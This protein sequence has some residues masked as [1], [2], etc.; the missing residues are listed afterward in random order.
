MSLNYQ[1]YEDPRKIKL[2]LNVQQYNDI[3]FKPK[4]N[5]KFKENNLHCFAKNTNYQRNNIKNTQINKLII[6]TIEPKKDKKGN[7]INEITKTKKITLHF[8]KKQRRIMKIWLTVIM[9]TYNV[10][11]DYLKEQFK[12][13]YELVIK[14]IQISKEIKYKNYILNI[15][16]KDAVENPDQYIRDHYLIDNLENHIKN[17]KTELNRL[18]KI[19]KSKQ[20]INML[21]SLKYED[22]RTELRFIKWILQADSI[23]YFNSKN[24]FKKCQPHINAMDYA[25][26]E[27]VTNYKTNIQKLM[28]GTITSFNM[29]YKTLEHTFL[30]V[31]HGHIEGNSFYKNIFGNFANEY[32]NKGKK[33]SFNFSSINQEVKVLFNKNKTKYIMLV[34]STSKII[35]KKE[36]KNKII[37]LDVG[38]RTFLTGISERRI[39]NIGISEK[40]IENTK[41]LPNND[42]KNMKQSFVKCYNR[43]DKLRYQI[44]KKQELINNK[45]YTQKDYVKIIKN[46]KN[47]RKKEKRI[48]KKLSNK[49]DD[50]D[51]KT[52]KYLVENYDTILIGNM[53]TKSITK[54]NKEDNNNELSKLNK[55]LA[56]SLKF[57]QFKERLA[58]KCQEYRRHF[59]I[60][61]EAHTS[62]TCSSCGFY[63]SDLGSNKT[64]NCD[65]CKMIMDRD[66]N[67]ARN[68]Y[69]CSLS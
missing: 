5:I 32:I 47:M 25:V 55:R 21:S 27:A 23:K 57:Y 12:E 29:N 3:L 63:K 40:M 15:G 16:K 51:W 36:A 43:V 64:F 62:K 1:K 54:N 22:I 45:K 6:P 33:E 2:K 28:K 35:P 50:F 41:I 66:I 56:Y 13:L 68:I 44:D 59:K 9:D 48:N 30:T 34:P 39:E 38:L 19:I 37:S 65:K 53:S 4:I 42:E 7:N 10:T 8:N 26:K 67:G 17:R 46:I 31:Y 58:F 20:N 61:D 11:I 60:I 24:E 69:L 18:F 14:C 49:V 52:C